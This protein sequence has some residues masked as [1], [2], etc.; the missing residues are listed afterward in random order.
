MFTLLIHITEVPGI[1]IMLF[2]AGVVA[3]ELAVFRVSFI[4]HVDVSLKSCFEYLR[5]CNIMD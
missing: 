1:A 2:V 5:L 4:A 3:C